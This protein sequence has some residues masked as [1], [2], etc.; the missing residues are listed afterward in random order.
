MILKNVHINVYGLIHLLWARV[1]L[2]QIF[3]VVL[4]A[5]P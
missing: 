3:S 1:E 5:V 2:A 4:D